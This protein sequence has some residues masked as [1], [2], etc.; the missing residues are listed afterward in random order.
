MTGT[1]G[2][3]NECT[4]GEERGGEEDWGG[5]EAEAGDLFTYLLKAY[6]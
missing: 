6:I 5:E 2:G 1:V 3:R 4:N